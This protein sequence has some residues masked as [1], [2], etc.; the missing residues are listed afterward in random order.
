APSYL[1]RRG[2]SATEFFSLVLAATA[3]MMLLAGATSLMVIFLSIEL[4]SLALYVLSGFAAG[5]RKSQEAGMKYLLLG[6]FASAVLLFGMALVYGET[7]HTQ[8][9]G[10]AG[11]IHQLH[12]VDPLLI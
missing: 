9:E 5:E 12:S 3:G 11:S 8:L 1:E 2:V 6:S 7:G 10:I 4:L